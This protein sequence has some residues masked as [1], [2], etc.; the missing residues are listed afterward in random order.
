MSCEWSEKIFGSYV[1]TIFTF[2]YLWWI[3]GLLKGLHL[4]WWCLPQHHS[5][6]SWHRICLGWFV[7]HLVLNAWL[8]HCNSAVKFQDLQAYRKIQS[9]N[10]CNCLIFDFKQMFLSFQMI[11]RFETTAIICASLI[12]IL[13]SFALIIKIL[14]LAY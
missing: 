7:F 5:W 12:S 13:E 10:G 14:K 11:F 1:H 4:V 8:L 9:A 2:F 3:Q 6:C